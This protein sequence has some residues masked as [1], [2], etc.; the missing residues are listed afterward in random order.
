MV[1]KGKP[2]RSKA[3]LFFLFPVFMFIF[4]AGWIMVWIDGK[5]PVSKMPEKI[6]KR[7]NI[8]IGAIPLESQEVEAV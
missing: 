1:T 8:T 3:M 5:K 7:D 2:K 4:A 6:V